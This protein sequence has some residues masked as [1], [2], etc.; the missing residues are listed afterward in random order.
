MSSTIP[1]PA[2]SP[3]PVTADTALFT[4][5][6]IESLS[7][8]F[9]LCTY[10]PRTGHLDVFYLVDEDGGSL[11]QELAA[12][13]DAI[14]IPTAAKRVLENNP[15]YAHAPSIDF[16]DLRTWKSNLKLAQMMGLSD[17][18]SVNDPRASSSYSQ[19]LRPVCDTDP[20]YDPINQHP[21][22][23]GYNSAN[24]DTSILAL[25]FMEAF[26]H[27]G[28]ALQQ[29]LNPEAGFT[30]AKASIV[31]SYNDQMFEEPWKQYMP[32]FLTDGPVANGQGWTSIPH[33]IRQGML[34]SGRHIDVARFNEVQQR[35]GLK[36]LLGGLGRQI[37]ESDKLGSHN[38]A[39]TSLEELYELMAY[40]VSDV[41]GLA[42]LFEHPTYSS[43]FDLKKR[44]LDTYP[45][46]IY[47]KRKDAYAPDM[48]PF[49]VRRN[50]LTPDSTSAKFVGLILS[51]YGP[52]KDLESVSFLYPSEQVAREKGIER[53]DVLEQCREFFYEHFDQPE[54]R[55]QFDEVYQYYDSIRGMN[56]ND[57]EEYAKDWP[58]PQIPGA[59][60]LPAHMLRDVPKRPN[61]LPYFHADGSPSTCFA[62]FSTGGIHGAEAAWELYE[63]D[64]AQWEA[65]HAV[66][67]EVKRLYPDP[68][69]VRKAREVTLP[70]G[71]VIP[72]KEV[73]TSK[74]TLKA[75]KARSEVIAQLGDN[76]DPAALAAIEEEYAG[77]GYKPAKP[78]PELF[79]QKSDGATK[80]KAR[81]TFTSV[82]PHVIHEDFT[83]YYP[84]MLR[85]MSAFYNA[86]LGEDR[87]AKILADKD[88]YGVMMKDPSLTSEERS[89]LKVLR[90]GT[91]LILN[92]ASGAGDTQHKTPIRV[93]NSIIS[94][95]IIG[96]L[97]SWRIGQAQT[98]AGARIISTN[99]DGLYSV[100]DE[101]TNNR[102]LAEQQALINIEI[103]PEPMMVVSKD[104]NNR[105]E[106]EA[107]EEGTPPWEADFLAA[108]GGSLACHEEPQPSK[109]LAHPAVLDW[110]LARYLRLV[111]GGYTP[112][113]RETPL[114]LA[115]PLDERMGKTLLLEAVRDNDPV[116]A[117]RLFQNVIAAS[118]GTITFPFAADPVDPVEPDPSVITN[119]RALQH[120]NR[121]FIVHQ[122]KP[123]ALSLR[124]AGARV[125]NAAT[126]LKR[127]RD[128][129]SPIATSTDALEILRANG[130]A[131]DRAE[132]IATSRTMLPADQDV[133]VRKVPGIDPSWSIIIENGDLLCMSEDKLRDLL[134]CLDLDVYNQMLAS[135]FNTNWKHR[136]VIHPDD[137]VAQD[138]AEDAA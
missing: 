91:K 4:F 52:M 56:F 76:P 96:Q 22:L 37:M 129:E 131:R 70:D 6:D 122:A 119:A 118:A 124:A 41:V 105:L 65:D 49:R 130:F 55:A 90:D 36:R 59:P 100:L 82:E 1:T 69:D 48:R 19:H 53:V 39:I 10:T 67:E 28:S 25:Y 108:S 99:T 62:T 87:Y 47:E 97:F 92:S 110:A 31:R 3:T 106:L 136:E 57:S 45:E 54:I 23:A 135:T 11:H 7:N 132:A 107:L 16:E 26:S 123:G 80:L 85:N 117:A 134:G 133:V 2:H 74:T 88:R 113:W 51:P 33:R 12:R 64:I 78:R 30:P 121:M 101:E 128:N 60:G 46:T 75:L 38:A 63:A 71:R 44:L 27:L 68:H 127:K 114:T 126:V 61:N 81:Y 120:Y 17:A 66:L 34:H 83:S 14:N 20:G 9:T 116:L 43:G 29:G 77:H 111:V 137:P 13:G 79:D 94:M 73:L 104:S 95:R 138:D 93:N 112:P 40:N 86:D 98:L 35:V 15:A 50:R 32:K 58:N 89:R 125:V 84:N 5:Y 109:S 24:Y 42:K 103:E 72:Y 8:V 21:Y 115:E 18:D 102:V